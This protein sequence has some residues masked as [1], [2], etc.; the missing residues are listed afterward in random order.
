V[1]VFLVLDETPFYQPAY[2]DDLLR[3]FPYTV[4]GA[5][6]V[7]RIPRSG[8]LR[9]YL[10][11]NIWR[12]RPLEIARL[13]LQSVRHQRVRLRCL[14]GQNQP[15]SVRSVLQK[16][17]VSYFEIEKNINEKEYLAAISAAKPDVILNSSSPI[18]G[19]RLLRIPSICCLNRHSSLLPAHGGLW[20]VFHAL[21][22]GD[23]EIGVSVHVMIRQIDGGDVISFKRLPVLPGR[24]LA[25]HYEMCFQASATVSLDALARASRADLTPEKTDQPPSY[26]SFPS[27]ESWRAFREDGWRFA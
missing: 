12:L 22:A 17:D 14:G 20:P 11:R 18:F 1:R 7:T 16:H 25:E 4:V 6:V 3:A 10:L 23:E 19:E 9:G 26:A 15:A 5:A 13:G 27:A 24:S 21:A 8:N 2:V